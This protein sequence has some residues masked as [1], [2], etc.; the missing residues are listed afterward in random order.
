MLPSG[1][2]V[3]KTIQRGKQAEVS[4]LAVIEAILEKIA[5]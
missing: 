5:Y 3:S 2:T 4:T 1:I